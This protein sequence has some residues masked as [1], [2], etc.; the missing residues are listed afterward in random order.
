MQLSVCQHWLNAVAE[1]APVLAN[2][3]VC[4]S[5]MLTSAGTLPDSWASAAAFPLLTDLTLGD[6]PF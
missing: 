4:F 5:T 1:L 2:V 6:L 3:Y